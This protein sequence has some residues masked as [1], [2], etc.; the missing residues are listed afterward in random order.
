MQLAAPSS[1]FQSS[2]KHS[3]PAPHHRCRLVSVCWY[4]WP[5]SGPSGCISDL[6]VRSTPSALVR[7]H[8]KPSP[9]ASMHVQACHCFPTCLEDACSVSGR[10]CFCFQK[11]DRYPSGG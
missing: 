6:T 3:E 5:V 11:H 8:Q 4:W 9:G 2:Q 7:L 1:M 10:P